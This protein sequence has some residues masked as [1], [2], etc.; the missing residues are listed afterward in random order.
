MSEILMCFA[1]WD[2]MHECRTP[3][4]CMCILIHFVCIIYVHPGI[5]CVFSHPVYVYMT[6]TLV[7]YV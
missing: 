2:C 3:W 4:Y 7:L 5:G 6:D 1:V